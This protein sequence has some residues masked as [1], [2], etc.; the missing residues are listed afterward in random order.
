MSVTINFTNAEKMNLNEDVQTNNNF[1]AN[2]ANSYFPKKSLIERELNERI[3]DQMQDRQKWYGSIKAGLVALGITENSDSDTV[4]K[5]KSRNPIFMQTFQQLRAEISDELFP[6]SGMVNVEL[7]NREM[8]S[9]KNQN[10]NLV[11]DFEELAAMAK[12]D[13]NYKIS[14]EWDEFKQELERGMGSAFLTGSAVFKVYYDE[15]LGRPTVYHILPENVLV[16]PSARSLNT[17]LEV[18]HIFELSKSQIEAFQRSGYFADVPLQLDEDD[19]IDS[20]N[21]T[22]ERDKNNN[23]EPNRTND[24]DKKY[25]F[26]ETDLIF[27][28]DHYP[29]QMILGSDLMQQ[30]Y[31]LGVYP[32]KMITFLATGQTMNLTRNWKWEK[33]YRPKKLNNLFMQTYLP[34]DLFGGIGLTQTSLNLHRTATRMQREIED[35]LYLANHPSAIMNSDLINKDTTIDMNI[36]GVSVINSM[37]NAPLS[38]YFK[39]LNFQNPAAIFYDYF[40]DI[41]NKISTGAGLTMLK[42]DQVTNIGTPALL[43]MMEKESKPMSGVLKRFIDGINSMLEILQNIMVEEMGDEPFGNANSQLTNR[44]VY[45]GLFSLQSACDP[46][47]CNNALRILQM[48]TALEAAMQSPQL[49]NMSVLLTRFFTTLKIPNPA[50]LLVSPEQLQ[51]QQQ[52]QQQQQEQQAQAAQQQ[53][54]EQNNILKSDIDSKFDKHQKEYETDMAKIQSDLEVER[55][56]LQFETFK[57]EKEYEQKY[58]DWQAKMYKD[59]TS[60]TLGRVKEELEFGVE[61]EELLPSEIK[62]LFENPIV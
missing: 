46:T 10:P 5:S 27:T 36:G 13:I 12:E 42:S 33:N 41:E 24:K 50:E 6:A 9:F 48:Q 47:F 51:Q 54:T 17:A 60:Y 35:A 4:S 30:A 49:T 29:D 23:I 18:S 28:L 1:Y 57:T 32:Y 14:R 37:T 43:S 40:K 31:P 11:V 3:N 44:Q 52:Q 38:E 16:D 45:S 55:E 7:K 39:Q 56:R 61:I 62:E 8:M 22:A 59:F 20:S 2:L 19:P 26:V 53:Q 58:K 34:G 21:V 25:K 15:W